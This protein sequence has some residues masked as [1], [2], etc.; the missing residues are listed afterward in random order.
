MKL[1]ARVDFLEK[2][3]L[4]LDD[5]EMERTNMEFLLP[6]LPLYFSKSMLRRFSRII[7]EW[8]SNSLLTSTSLFLTK[9][10]PYLSF[11]VKPEQ[12]FAVYSFNNVL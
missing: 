2:D 3:T 5:L 8:N 1:W 9:I 10:L 4:K 7:S 11:V 12:R 6:P